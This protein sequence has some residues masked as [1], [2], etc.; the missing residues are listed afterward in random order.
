MAGR[1]RGASRDGHPA[2]AAVVRVGDEMRL[3]CC[4]VAFALILDASASL[5][6][7]QNR[8]P[9]Q[10]TVGGSEPLRLRGYAQRTHLLGTVDL[11]TVA[12]Y[13]DGPRDRAALASADIPKAL[14]IEV[15]YEDDLRRRVAIDWR[16]ELVPSLEPQAV[17]HLRGTFAPLRR[18]D[19]VQVEYLPE[20]GTTVRVTKAVAVSGAHHD[21]ML[22]F[23]DHW[24]GDRPVSADIKRT[25][26]AGM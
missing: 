1:C 26:L 14:R 25:L 24:L 13:S 20:K 10:I 11:Y 15:T 2:G 23:L 22:A 9:E 4:C 18:D 17:A 3:L 12:L 16:R 5:T 21:L 19:V 6:A 7:R 8:P